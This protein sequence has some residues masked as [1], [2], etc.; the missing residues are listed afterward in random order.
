MHY[1]RLYSGFSQLLASLLHYFFIIYNLLLFGFTDQF[2]I[3]FQELHD[4]SMTCCVATH[5]GSETPI[6][7]ELW[8]KHASSTH[9]MKKTQQIL[10]YICIL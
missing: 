7:P 10:N 5:R 8:F 9:C 6:S 3:P 4:Y 1:F 2:C